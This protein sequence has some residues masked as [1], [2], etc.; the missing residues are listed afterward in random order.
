MVF[1]FGSG[2]RFSFVVWFLPLPCLVLASV[3]SVSFFVWWAWQVKRFVSVAPPKFGFGLGLAGFR[4]LPESPAA[5]FGF[6]WVAFSSI[7][8]VLA[9]ASGCP[10]TSVAR[11]R[12]GQVVL[13]ARL[14]GYRLFWVGLGLL[15]RLGLCAFVPAAS[16]CKPGWAG[17]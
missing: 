13:P 9:S 16:A 7:C 17:S 1:W 8:L 11:F 14:C 10:H 12:F 6:C 5:T 2:F 4:R 15:L 3:C